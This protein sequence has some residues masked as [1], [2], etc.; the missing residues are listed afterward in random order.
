MGWLILGFGLG[1]AFGVV[2]GIG[3]AARHWRVL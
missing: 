2:C 1:M 3:A